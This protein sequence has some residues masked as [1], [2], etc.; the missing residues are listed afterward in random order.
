M[1]HFNEK[2]VLEGICHI[3]RCAGEKILAVYQNDFEI[4]IKSDFSPL[5]EADLAA[6]QIIV[7][8]LKALTP[9]IPVLSEE[10]AEI[11]WTTRKSWDLYW[12]VEPLDGTKEFINKNGEFTQ[13]FSI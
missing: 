7:A 12:L 1:S 8:G 4:Q 10:D 5:T 3:A 13:Q 6:H 9:D 11:S 2:L